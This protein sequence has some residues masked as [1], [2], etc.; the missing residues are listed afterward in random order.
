MVVQL[1]VDAAQLG[2]VSECDRI[3]AFRL[4]GVRGG[5]RQHIQ[6]S[7]EVGVA[8]IRVEQQEC[9]AR[10]GECQLDPG[11]H[12]EPLVSGQ[13]LAAGADLSCGGGPDVR[14]QRD[15][16]VVCNGDGLQAVGAAGGDKAAGVPL[17]VLIA[18]GTVPLPSAV[19]RSVDLKIGLE[20]VRPAVHLRCRLRPLFVG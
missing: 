19:S 7:C 2:Q 5:D 8:E 3:S 14:K 18:D 9:L 16:V 15:V 20:V 10:H 11:E 17:A 1:L 6:D 4:G 13:R 12:N